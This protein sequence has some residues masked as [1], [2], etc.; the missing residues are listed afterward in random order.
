MRN[1]STTISPFTSLKFVRSQIFRSQ[2]KSWKVFAI[3]NVSPGVERDW[4]AEE[5][6]RGCCVALFAPGVW[7]SY[8]DVLRPPVGRLHGGRT[9]YATKWE[10]YMEGAVRSGIATPRA[11][12]GSRTIP[13]KGGANG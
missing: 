12:P 11:V 3:T 2:P 7:T 13:V 1:R 4:S 9:E 10:G 5:S 6:T 8:G